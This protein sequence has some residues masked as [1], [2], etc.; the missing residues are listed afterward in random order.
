VKNALLR[1]DAALARSETALERPKMAHEREE[2]ALMRW[3]PALAC[4][5]G[6]SEGVTPV[7]GP[8]FA[9]GKNWR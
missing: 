5:P 2:L 8:R 6:K 1:G 3:K 9:S 4:S 7:L